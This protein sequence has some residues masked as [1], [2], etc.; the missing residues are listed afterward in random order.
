MAA[1]CARRGFRPVIASPSVRQRCS[2]TS[3]DPPSGAMTDP[4]EVLLKFAFLAVLYLFLLWIARSALR[5]LRRPASGPGSGSAAVAGAAADARARLIVV[6]GGGGQRVGDWYEIGSGLTIG[7]APAS[8]IRI[9]D[10][11]AS[12]RHARVYGADGAVFL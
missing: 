11:Y 1:R 10:G 8:E 4:I 9:D 3:T 12:G 6:Q 2:S 5:D 7:R